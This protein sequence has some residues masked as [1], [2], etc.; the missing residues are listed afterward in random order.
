MSKKL[1][2]FRRN[3]AGFWIDS[4]TGRF[5]RKVDYLPYIEK[6][7]KVSQ[8]RSEAAKMYWKEV[9][10]LK[11]LLGISTKDARTKLKNS[12]KYVRRRGKDP[13][14]WREF[15]KESRKQNMDKEMRKAYKQRL[16]DEGVELTS[17]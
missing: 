4:K 15:W 5:A 14:Q 12:P 9:N 7:K 16:E 10:Q 6:E 8:K 1:P 11:D 13:K 3:S 17:W 2:A